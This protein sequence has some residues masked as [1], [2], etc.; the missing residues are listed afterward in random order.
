VAQ[1][2]GVVPSVDELALEFN[3]VSGWCLSS[4]SETC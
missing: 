4:S 3:D 1:G 2:L